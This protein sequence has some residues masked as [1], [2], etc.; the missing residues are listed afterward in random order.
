MER[1]LA[2][3]KED[4]PHLALISV[5]VSGVLYPPHCFN[6]EFYN[7]ANILSLCPYNDDLWFFIMSVLNDTPKVLITNPLSHPKES[8][9]AIFETPNLWEINV[10][11]NRNYEQFKALLHAYPEAKKK[12]VDSVDSIMS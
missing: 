4:T 2:L 10:D 5:G 3:L 8:A 12:I 9:I 1:Y 11:Q 7:T 6:D